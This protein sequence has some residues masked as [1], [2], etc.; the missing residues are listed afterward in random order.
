MED[1]LLLYLNNRLGKKEEGFSPQDMLPGPVVTISREVGCAGV[2]LAN[3]LA[4][5]LNEQGGKHKWKVFSKEIFEETARELEMD[6]QKLKNILKAEGR[7][8]FDEIL[9]ALGDKRFKSERKIRKTVYDAIRTIAADGYC[10]IVGRGGNLITRDIENSLHV[11]LKAPLDWRIKK[12]AQSHGI[13][14]TEAIKFIEKTEKERE[15]VRK[16]IQL[17]A[18]T[19]EQYDIEINVASFST[20][21]TIEIIEKTMLLKGLTT[22]QKEKAVVPSISK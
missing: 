2:K 20:I 6:Q 3:K 15:S 1:S 13:S 5:K 16:N 22:I 8:T 7:N 17:V 11:R 10:I 21:H 18:L 9:G 19:D 14:I 4:K 12:I